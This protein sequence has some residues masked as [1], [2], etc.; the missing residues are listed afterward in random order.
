MKALRGFAALV[1]CLVGVLVGA[2][3]GFASVT[4]PVQVT[5]VM[6]WLVPNCDP[7][8]ANP[9]QASN[10]CTGAGGGGF[11]MLYCPEENQ[12]A[13]TKALEDRGLKRMNF[14]FDHQG[15]TVILNV[16]SFSH[17]WIEPYTGPQFPESETDQG[18]IE[19]L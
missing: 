12:D 10:W 17:H 13:V 18:L 15:A 3:P 9:A 11:L 5:S 2:A 19:A 14:R 1:A 7:F 8:N 6:P 4:T 16:A